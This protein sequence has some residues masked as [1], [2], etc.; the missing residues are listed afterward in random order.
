MSEVAA[1]HSGD[2]AGQLL[3]IDQILQP[4]VRVQVSS[5]A[6]T[7]PAVQHTS[8]M[9]IN[10]LSRLDRIIREISLVCPS[11]VPLTGRI[12]PLAGRQLFLDE[13]LEAGNAAIGVVPLGSAVPDITL[14]VGPQPDGNLDFNVYGEAWWGGIFQEPIKYTGISRLPFGPYMAACVAVGEIFK[15][16][17]MLTS[18]RVERRQAFFSMWSYK[19]SVQPDR[20]G[21]D[22]LPLIDLSR[23]ALA[24]VG[25]VG[26]T[27]LHTLWATDMT[28]LLRIADND[29]AGVEQSNLNRYP[30]FGSASVGR[31]KASEA[32]RVLEDA[33]F[34][35]S[36]FDGGFERIYADNSR[37]VI[38]V[39]AVD[40]NI[41][42]SNIQNQYAP[43]ILSASTSDLRAEV[44]RCGPPGVGAC[45]ACFN[46]PERA[47]TD[48]ELR[49]NLRKSAENILQIASTTGFDVSDIQE[50]LSSPQKCGETSTR[51]LEELQRSVHE[52]ERFAVGFV[53]VMAGTMLAAELVKTAGTLDASVLGE[54]SN[55]A[56]FQFFDPLGYTNRSTHYP[57]DPECPKCAPQTP[58][59]EEWKR[60]FENAWKRRAEMY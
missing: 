28:G 1:R 57:R 43:I 23:S 41:A 2:L 25:A 32:A 52:P 33:T 47:P 55:R 24:G 6:A 35:I 38:L 39:S 21:L 44:L 54:R 8:W 37:P 56:V 40:T 34:Q 7:L 15:R 14:Q 18:R 42:R 49:I 4:A 48:E 5:S 36:A 22:V 31:Q 26:S 11:S 50:W 12:V 3:A 58:A 30:L 45:L 46:P 59:S 19:A 13:A 60:R 51:I 9:L 29:P 53:S 16:A 10:M 20:S 17:R 27:L